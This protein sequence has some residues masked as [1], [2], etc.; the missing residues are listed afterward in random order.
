[1]SSLKP[2]H[3]A[4]GSGRGSARRGGEAGSGRIGRRQNSSPRRQ[5]SLVPSKASKTRRLNISPEAR[6]SETR[7]R[8]MEE[9]NGR[10]TSGLS[11]VDIGFITKMRSPL[12][13][14]LLTSGPT[15][16]D[17]VSPFHAR[18]VREFCAMGTIWLFHSKQ[19]HNESLCIAQ[20]GSTAQAASTRSRSHWRLSWAVS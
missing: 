14:W 9:H 7:F 19:Q 2:G 3:I 11:A 10:L 5:A 13:S 6:A 15:L 16:F 12:C 8:P 20:T 17:P 18:H 4:G 1:M